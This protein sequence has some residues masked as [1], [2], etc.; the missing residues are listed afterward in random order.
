MVIDFL[1]NITRHFKTVLLLADG[2]Y[3][4]DTIVLYLSDAE[5]FH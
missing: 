1:K 3:C 5:P 2:H 4:C